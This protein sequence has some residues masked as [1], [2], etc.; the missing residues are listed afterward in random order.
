[1]IIIDPLYTTMTGDLNNN[2]DVKNWI[3]NVRGLKNHYGASVIVTHHEKKVSFNQD[4]NA[5][6]HGSDSM[7]GSAFWGAFFNHIFS[8]KKTRGAFILSCD[9]QRSAK[10]VERMELQLIQPI[11]LYFEILGDNKVGEEKVAYFL[12]KKDYTVESLAM[13]MGVSEVYVRKL[14]RKMTGKG[15]VVKR[16]AHSRPVIYGLPA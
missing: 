4:G 13:E 16:D 8:F 14:F 7:Y 10:V 12:G 9:V 11:P 5:I 6:E 2:K 15:T 1:M 3:K